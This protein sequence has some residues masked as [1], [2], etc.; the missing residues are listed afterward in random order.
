[1]GQG[2]SLVRWRHL[3]EIGHKSGSISINNKEISWLV[4]LVTHW[5]DL[6]QF[7]SLFLSEVNAVS[8]NND[9]LSEI[10]ITSKSMVVRRR[11]LVDRPVVE[12]RV[13]NW[14]LALDKIYFIDSND[15]WAIK[16]LNSS[17]RVWK[18]H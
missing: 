6:G 7:V 3:S 1:M 2:G 5:N 4:L 9:I 16:H 11:W 17:S 8:V 15:H 10:G 18:E 14:V 13:N 12:W